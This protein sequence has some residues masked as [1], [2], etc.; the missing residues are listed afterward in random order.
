MANNI[1]V[2]MVLEKLVYKELLTEEEMNMIL[3]EYMTE[4]SEEVA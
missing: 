2:I 4:K 1:A 3:H